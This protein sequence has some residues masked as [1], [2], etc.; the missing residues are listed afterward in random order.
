[1]QCL[2]RV[3]FQN[4]KCTLTKKTGWGNCAQLHKGIGS[5]QEASVLIT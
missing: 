1:M 2:V 5:I 4:Q 3:G